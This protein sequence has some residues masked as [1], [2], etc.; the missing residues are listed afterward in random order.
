MLKV[1][2]SLSQPAVEPQ[3]NSQSAPG[4]MSLRCTSAKPGRIPAGAAGPK[5]HFQERVGTAS[6][7]VST[8]GSASSRTRDGVARASSG[9]SLAR[10]GLGYLMLLQLFPAFISFQDDLDLRP[11]CPVIIKAAAHEQQ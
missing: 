5:S 4:D 3:S 10:L 9:A 11:E 8:H 2:F 7:S 1:K 6:R